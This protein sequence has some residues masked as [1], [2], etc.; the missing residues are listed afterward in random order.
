M[1]GKPYMIWEFAQHLKK[2][3]ALMGLDVG[4]Y[5]SAY[6]SLNGRQYQEFIDPEVDLTEVPRPT[7]GHASWIRPLTVP[8]SE[9]R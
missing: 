7:W 6:A 2:E 3:H 9:Q 4:V 5:V 1:A 8:L